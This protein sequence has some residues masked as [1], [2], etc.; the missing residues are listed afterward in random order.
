MAVVAL[1]RLIGAHAPEIAAELAQRL[2]ADVVDRRIIDEVARRLQMPPEEV[3]ALDEVPSTV[4][5]R[6][7]E[8]LAMTSMEWGPPDVPEAWTPPFPGDPNFRDP[9]DAAA[10]A[11]DQVI[12]QAALG[13]NAVIVGRGAP[14]VLRDQPAVLRVLLDADFDLRARDVATR[15]SLSLQEAQRL[16]KET[17]ANWT[18]YVRHYYKA[19]L[20]DPLHYDLILNSGRVSTKGAAEVIASAMAVLETGPPS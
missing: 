7:L 2:N 19:D 6:L 14:F 12:R 15:Q 20:R 1:E 10:H 13:G 5:E 8:Q 17:D 9:K 3:E 11:T 18:A 4:L 16:V